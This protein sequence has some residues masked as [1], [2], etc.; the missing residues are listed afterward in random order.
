MENYYICDF[1]SY[2]LTWDVFARDGNTLVEDQEIGHILSLP[3]TWGGNYK[4]PER[5]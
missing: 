5:C 4:I 1:T 3:S 2:K